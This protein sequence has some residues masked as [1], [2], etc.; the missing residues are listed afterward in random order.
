LLSDKF[1][2][3]IFPQITLFTPFSGVNCGFSEY[4]D[5]LK[6]YI[7]APPSICQEKPALK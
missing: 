6:Y 4:F 5:N 1:V 7:V 3:K 2:D